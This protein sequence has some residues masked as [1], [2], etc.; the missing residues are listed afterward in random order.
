M[1]HTV[2][3]QPGMLIKPECGIGLLPSP[4]RMVPENKCILCFGCFQ[5]ISPIVQFQFVGIINKKALKCWTGDP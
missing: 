1:H 5:G 4:S 2:F 3:Q